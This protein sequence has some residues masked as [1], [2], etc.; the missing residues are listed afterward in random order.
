MLFFPLIAR[1]Q[2]LTNQIVQ[3]MAFAAFGRVIR[4]VERIVQI[5]SCSAVA[6][7][8]PTGSLLVLVQ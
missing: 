1:H 3:L 2:L 8:N 7:E 5:D 4:G 6:A